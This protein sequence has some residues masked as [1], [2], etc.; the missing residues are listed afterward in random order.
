M[1]KLVTTL[2][3]SAIVGLLVGLA[4]RPYCYSSPSSN[5]IEPPRYNGIIRE[6]RTPCVTDTYKGNMIKYTQM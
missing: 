6:Y 1:M 4:L 5:R 2:V 3:L